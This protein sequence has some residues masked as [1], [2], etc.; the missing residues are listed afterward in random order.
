[1]VLTIGTVVGFRSWKRSSWGRPQWDRLRLRIPFKIGDVV[2]KVALARWARTFSA[3]IS[4]GVP[5]LQAID[6]TGGTAGNYHIEKAMADVKESVQRGGSIAEPL[7]KSEHF[8]TMVAHMVGVGEESGFVVG[9]L[10][11]V[12]DFDEVVGASVI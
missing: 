11:K 2:Q 9:L 4:S 6:I 10:R 8:P 5:I 7:R 3:L 1:V 12:A